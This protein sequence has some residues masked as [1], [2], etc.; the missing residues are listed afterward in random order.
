VQF[1]PRCTTPECLYH[2]QKRSKTCNFPKPFKHIKI[3]L[4]CDLTTQYPV[5]PPRNGRETKEK[6]KKKD[7]KRVIYIY[8]YI[9]IY[10]WEI[11]FLY[12]RESL[13]GGLFAHALTLRS[14]FTTFHSLP[15]TFETGFEQLRTRAVRIRCVFVYVACIFN[16]RAHSVVGCP[17]K[18]CIIELKTNRQ[19][20]KTNPTAN[21]K[22]S[23]PFS[24]YP[25]TLL[26]PVLNS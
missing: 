25:S 24:T 18:N 19:Q 11:F 12:Q 7:R 13:Q 21:Y 10:I 6:R 4:V 23:I 26:R 20:N 8:I 14:P 3:Y 5:I 16:F 22:A 15:N 9:Y 1:V 2:A 17:F